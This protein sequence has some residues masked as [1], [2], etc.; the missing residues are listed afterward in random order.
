MSVLLGLLLLL[1]CGG[2]ALLWWRNRSTTRVLDRMLEEILD[3]E[4][5]SQSELEEGAVSALAAKMRRVQEKVDASVTDAEQEREAVKQL[6][7]NMAHQLKTPLAGLVMYREMLEDENL[8][9]NTRRQFLEKMKK[10]TEKLDW[11]LNA[12]FKMVEL[13]QGAVVFDA[14]ALPRPAQASLQGFPQGGQRAANIGERQAQRQLFVGGLLLAALLFRSG[15]RLL[16]GLFLFFFLRLGHQLQP[17]GTRCGR[18]AQLVAEADAHTY[19]QQQQQDEQQQKYA[20]Y[21]QCD[22]QGPPFLLFSL[23]RQAPL[24]VQAHL[25]VGLQPRHL[26]QILQ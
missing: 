19:P 6:I 26:R 18:D 14:Q 7:S 24:V 1:A 25:A 15:R 5:I 16:F 20:Q 8:D 13:E 3:G 2:C 17:D 22:Q 21:P 11:I 9:A 4:P 10:Q 12:L 23:R